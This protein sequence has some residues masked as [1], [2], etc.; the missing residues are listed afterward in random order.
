MIES[1]VFY[2]FVVGASGS[3]KNAIK[4]MLSSG[5]ELD[6]ALSWRYSYRQSFGI[7]FMMPLHNFLND[8][9]EESILNGMYRR[10]G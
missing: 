8:K 5:L 9:C 2:D 1:G 10:V 3:L 4:S 6:Y 7:R